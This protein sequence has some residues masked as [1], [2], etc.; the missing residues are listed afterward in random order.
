MNIRNSLS[1][2]NSSNT[3]IGCLMVI[4]IIF[5]ILKLVGAIQWSWWWVMSP[6]ILK[7]TVILFFI[8]IVGLYAI[9]SVAKDK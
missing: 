6:L 1:E 9:G 3:G 7:G 8:I 4:Q 2:S 5:I